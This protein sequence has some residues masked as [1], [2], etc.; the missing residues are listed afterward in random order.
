[1]SEASAFGRGLTCRGGLALE[2]IAWW[3]F[4]DRRWFELRAAGAGHAPAGRPSIRR[5]G[6]RSTWLHS[7]CAADLASLCSTARL[8]GRFDR[9]LVG[10]LWPRAARYRLSS[11]K[12]PR[13]A[14]RSCER[15]RC[16]ASVISFRSVAHADLWIPLCG[17]C[18]WGATS[19]PGLPFQ[20]KICPW[21]QQQA[22]VGQPSWMAPLARC[23]PTPKEGWACSLMLLSAGE[24]R[25]LCGLKASK[26]SSE[27]SV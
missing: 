1:M 24:P 9:V 7:P 13:P 19:S 8:L 15:M 18:L 25:R 23:S 3:P 27:K 14:A 5:P 16:P 6:K 11:G 10:V 21:L 20:G 26:H 17:Y 12:G 22:S 4:A 2:Q